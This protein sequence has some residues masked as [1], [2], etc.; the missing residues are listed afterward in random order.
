MDS[1]PPELVV[2]V[3]TFLCT[4]SLCQLCGASKALRTALKDDSD[5]WE[6]A[7]QSTWWYHF[8]TLKRHDNFTFWCS[9]FA[10]RTVPPPDGY[11][12]YKEVGILVNYFSNLDYNPNPFIA[13]FEYS[14][15]F[16]KPE[17]DVVRPEYGTE[18][19]QRRVF[20]ESHAYLSGCLVGIGKPDTDHDGPL[21]DLKMDYDFLTMDAYV[22]FVCSS[23]GNFHCM[24]KNCSIEMGSQY[25][26]SRL[27][28]LGQMPLVYFE[29]KGRNYWKHS[30]LDLATQTLI[31]Q[32][33]EHV[34]LD[35]FGPYGSGL[36]RKFLIED[37]IREYI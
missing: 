11:H 14:T 1:L 10:I 7:L 22:C 18:Q 26:I 33:G 19:L 35:D 32:R 15:P 36:T 17:N 5:A 31:K 9:Q 37:I 21:I 3:C 23:T 24:H 2:R 4:V 34:N 27:G 16:T 8:D 29:I 28:P 13:Y 25:I 30:R 6:T 12:L 20:W